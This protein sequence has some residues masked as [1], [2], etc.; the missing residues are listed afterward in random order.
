MSPVF[1]FLLAA[2]AFDCI[3]PVA[4]RFLSP[5][6][7]QVILNSQ[8]SSKQEDRSTAVQ[9]DQ[10][11]LKKRIIDELNPTA[12]EAKKWNDKGVAART[13]AQIADRAP[14]LKRIT[15]ITPNT[16][17]TSQTTGFSLRAAVN[18][19]PPQQF[20]QVLYML[21]DITPQEARGI[22]VVSLCSNFLNAMKKATNNSERRV[23]R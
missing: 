17:L 4:G 3:N 1:I 18:V 12:V 13:Q 8:E 5:S 21:N 6:E 9:P 19:F 2:I 20:E 7:A 14:Q 16:D 15:G 23:M 22:A 11:R 10:L